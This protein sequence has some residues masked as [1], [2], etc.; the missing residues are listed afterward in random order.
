MSIY[1][2][3]VVMLCIYIYIYIC[4]CVC[5]CIYIYSRYAVHIYIY[6]DLFYVPCLKDEGNISTYREVVKCKHSVY[7]MGIERRKRKNEAKYTYIK[8]SVLFDSLQVHVH[9]TLLLLYT[10]NYKR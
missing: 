10:V 3:I 7:S 5:V 9:N 2:Y 6:K 8:C 4:V 1:I